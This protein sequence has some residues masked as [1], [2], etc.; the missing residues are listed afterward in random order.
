VKS[1]VGMVL[2]G[3]KRLGAASHRFR[4]PIRFSFAI[5]ADK[6]LDDSRP[7]ELKFNESSDFSA[8]AFDEM[9]TACARANG[10]ARSRSNTHANAVNYASSLY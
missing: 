9:T 3:Q 8:L 2:G 5:F 1:P 10:A 7:R 6:K 4:C